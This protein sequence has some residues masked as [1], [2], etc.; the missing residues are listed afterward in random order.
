MKKNVF[1]L[2][3]ILV[4][5]LIP[6]TVFA[7]D[8]YQFGFQVVKCDPNADGMTAAKCRNNYL[9]GSLDSYKVSNGGNLEPGTTIMVVVNLKVGTPKTAISL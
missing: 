5:L 2:L 1:L 3:S 6:N 7:A 4:V 8:P 9:N